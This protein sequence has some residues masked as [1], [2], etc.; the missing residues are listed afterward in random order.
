M[1]VDLRGRSRVL[2]ALPAVVAALAAAVVTGAPVPARSE[3]PAELPAR[4][5]VQ[6]VGTY[7]YLVQPDFD[8]L[9]PLREAVADTTI[10]LGTFDRLDGE[11]VM[12]AGVVY[13]VGTDGVPRPVD[14]DRTTP[15]FEGVAFAPQAR[16]RLSAGTTCADLGSVVDQLAGTSRGMVAVRVTGRF[17]TLTLRSIPRQDRPYP[18]LSEV[19]AEQVEFPLADVRGGLVGFRT[20]PDLLGIGQP[21]LHL[22]G[23]TRGATAGG[24]VLSCTTGPG[25]RLSVQRV[26]GVRVLAG[27]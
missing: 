10:G 14:L 27:D 20:G 21:G 15:F 17:S 25:A 23:L 6:Q 7:D 19:I 1:G 18:P 2:L 26:A 3:L 13:R 5:W 12:V 8:G 24:H 11:L 16:I 9:L 22:H 4:G